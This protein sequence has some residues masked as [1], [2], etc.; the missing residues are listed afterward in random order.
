MLNSVE[1]MAVRAK[2]EPAIAADALR[3]CFGDLV[4][5]ADVSLT[6]EPGEIFGLI[7]PNGAGK[8]TFIKMLITLLRPTSGSARVAGFDV[9]TQAS[10]VRRSIG[11]VPQMLSADGALTG[12]E[13]LLLSARLYA[14]ARR[15]RATR[16]AQALEIVNLSDAADRLVREYSGGMIRRLEI[17]QS[18]M[19]HPKILVMDEPT[20]GLDPVARRAVWDHV[21]W[22]RE[23]LGMTM[24]LTTHFM[25]EADDLCDRVA[26]MHQ[27]KIQIVGPPAELKARLSPGATLDDVFAHFTGVTLENGGSLREA[28][29]T[30]RSARQHG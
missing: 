24:F 9:I 22:L 8:S 16:I 14:I 6:V 19:H 15:E 3:R 10:D 5:V 13:N 12:Y 29:R 28:R 17:A 30:R 1:K 20:T 23:K 18:I 25:G 7:G 11:Y 21:R 27:G 2:A 4:A 26:L